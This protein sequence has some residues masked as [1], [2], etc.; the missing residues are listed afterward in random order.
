MPAAR[1]FVLP[2]LQE[3]FPVVLVE[4][5]VRGCAVVTSSA[6]GCAEVVGDAG[7]VVPV[8]DAAALGAAL[9]HLINH[10]DEIE[11]LGRRA[12]ERAEPFA[13]EVVANEFVTLYERCV[14][15]AGS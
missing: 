15:G 11:R 8:G 4:A 7:Q 5:M 2:S 14:A 9:A 13:P 6:E 10:P 3:N 1:V 12:R